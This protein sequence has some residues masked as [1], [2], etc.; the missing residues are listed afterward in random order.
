MPGMPCA[1][2]DSLG[3]W[4]SRPRP[5]VPPLRRRLATTPAAFYLVTYT[6]LL[7]VYCLALLVSSAYTM[8]GVL[9]ATCGTALGFVFPGLLAWR[10]E[11]HWR[12]QA[13]GA[14][15]VVLG[16]ALT[17]AGVAS[18]VQRPDDGG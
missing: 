18:A 8:A 6:C 15:L 17:V 11:A 12:W 1:L 2:Q 14:L 9:G 4:L 13:F 10:G 3:S 16:A 5:A 7:V